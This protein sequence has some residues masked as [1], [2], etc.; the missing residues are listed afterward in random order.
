MAE[1]DGFIA[2][3]ARNWQF[4]LSVPCTLAEVN[5]LFARHE[6][7]ARYRSVEWAQEYA[8]VGEAYAALL[9]LVLS[10]S[11]FEFMRENV[12]HVPRHDYLARR[13]PA[14]STCA[15][16]PDGQRKLCR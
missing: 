9:G 12:F 2:G 11:A 3:D 14:D 1:I 15:C 10:Y 6:A 16:P 13:A 8:Q 7:A 5:R 4:V